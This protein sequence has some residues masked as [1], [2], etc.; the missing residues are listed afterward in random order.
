[1][2]LQQLKYFIEIVNCGS[3]NKAAESLF[4]SQP[5]LSNAVKDLEA[6]VGVELFTRTPKGITLTM[7]GVEFLGYARQ[8]VEQASLRI[9]S[10]NV[11]YTKLLR[12]CSS[13]IPVAI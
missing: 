1:M 6:E 7:D 9:T 4:I 2:T 12:T 8:V 13:S 11:C 10:Y 3:I 5:S